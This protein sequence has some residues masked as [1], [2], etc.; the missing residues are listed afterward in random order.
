MKFTEKKNGEQNP[1]SP[2]EIAYYGNA[3]GGK[4][5]IGAQLG[6]SGAQTSAYLLTDSS[7]EQF[8]LKVPNHQKD[9]GWIVRQKKAIE[10]K[11]SYVGDYNGPICVPKTIQIGQDFVVEE[12]ASGQEFSAKMYDALSTKDKA[13]LAKDF[14]VFLNQSHQRTFQGNGETLQLGRASLQSIFDYFKSELSI[15]EQMVFLKYKQIF[16]EPHQEPQVLAFGDYRHQNMLWDSE[17]K[18]LSIIDFDCTRY[19]SVYKEFTPSAAASFH[20]SY[21]FLK[22]VVQAYNRLPKKHPIHLDPERVKANCILGIYHELGRCGISNGAPP[23]NQ[24][25]FI[26]FMCREIEKAFHV[27]P[28]KTQLRRKQHEDSRL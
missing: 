24:L 28:N 5:K 20:S 12:L 26:P 22:D 19:G 25:R 17:K 7:G 10:I 15:R 11:E 8:V 18:Q 3:L 16:E 13:K 4:Y 27:K 6:R 21:H 14:A 9:D 1:L 23:K 2:E